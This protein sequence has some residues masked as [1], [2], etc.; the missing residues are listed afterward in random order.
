MYN[1]GSGSSKLYGILFT[2]V[3]ENLGYNSLVQFEEIFCRC[4][5]K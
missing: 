5:N 2:D 3:E 1:V 4:D